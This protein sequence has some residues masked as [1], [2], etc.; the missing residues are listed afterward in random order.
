M[1][2]ATRRSLWF[3]AGLVTGAVA[4]VAA[5][6]LA[7]AYGYRLVSRHPR[8]LLTAAPAI[9]LLR[10]RWDAGLLELR[11]N[12]GRYVPWLAVPRVNPIV[13]VG[14]GLRQADTL[15]WELRS[16]DTSAEW[17]YIII[18]HT[19]TRGGTLAS[20]DRVHAARGWKGAGYHFIIR[21]GTP[22]SPSD[23]GTVEVTERWK[24]QDSGAHAGLQEYNDFGIGICVIGN[25]D[26]AT[27]SRA[28]MKALAMIVAALQYRFGIAQDHVL[29]HRD[30]RRTDCPGTHF[31]SYMLRRM[32]IPGSVAAHVPPREDSD[33]AATELTTDAKATTT[34][35]DPAM[36][37]SQTDTTST[38]SGG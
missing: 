6:V 33:P 7:T 34:D 38:T 26:R 4:V 8:L 25:F 35:V 29:L 10:E 24:A 11:A 3:V 36:V 32:T 23:A 20:I 14:D 13:G 21:A 5:A 18:H 27:P 37:P 9:D 22:E 17:K 2:T 12:Y 31:P 19:A 1:A 15:A 16:V 30:I 28:Q